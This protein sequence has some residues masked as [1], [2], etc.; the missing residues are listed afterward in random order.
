M[1]TQAQVKD[2]IEQAKVSCDLAMQNYDMVSAR[3][4]FNQLGYDD[5]DVQQILETL[6]DGGFSYCLDYRIPT[7]DGEYPMQSVCYW[8]PDQLKSRLNAIYIPQNSEV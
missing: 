6:A 8:G 1:L 5:D 2:A 3:S 4:V 7:K